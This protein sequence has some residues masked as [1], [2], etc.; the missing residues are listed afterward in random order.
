VQAENNNTQR[1]AEF[2]AMLVAYRPFIRKVI[3]ARARREDLE[4]LEQETFEDACR[5]WS[6]FRGEDY[7]FATW[8]AFVARAVIQAHKRYNEAKKRA[9][10]EWSLDTGY[11]DRSDDNGS[12]LH[13]SWLPA[14]PQNQLDYAELSAVLRNLSGT[15]DSEALMRIAMGDDLQDVATDFGVSRERVRQL[16]ERER[17]RLRDRQRERMAA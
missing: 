6:T 16:A 3:R 4:D 12:S 17:G 13:G 5:R 9:G 10:A 7:S 8:L 15:R 14:L 1:P 2:D 11:T